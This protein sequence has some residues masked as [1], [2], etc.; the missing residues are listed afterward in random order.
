MD[1]GNGNNH[2]GKEEVALHHHAQGKKTS[3]LGWAFGLETVRL[4]FAKLPRAHPAFTSS[5]TQQAAGTGRYR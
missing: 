2:Q 1:E 3:S 5:K 4:V